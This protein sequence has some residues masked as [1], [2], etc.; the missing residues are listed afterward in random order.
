MLSKF[1][2]RAKS[3]RPSFARIKFARN[4]A[5]YAFTP[6]FL[7]DLGEFGMTVTWN[8]R[9]WESVA[10]FQHAYVTAWPVELERRE[11]QEEIRRDTGLHDVVTFPWE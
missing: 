7:E 6:G 9:L 11:L 10:F 3:L 5:W 8:R 1:L 4:V 2:S